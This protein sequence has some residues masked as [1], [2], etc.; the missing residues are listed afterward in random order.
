MPAPKIYECLLKGICDKVSRTINGYQLPDGNVIIAEEDLSDYV[1]SV[2]EML[3][4]C[5]DEMWTDDNT[6]FEVLDALKACGTYLTGTIK[7]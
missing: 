6:Y 4:E 7:D 1:E 5:S 3:E 2:I